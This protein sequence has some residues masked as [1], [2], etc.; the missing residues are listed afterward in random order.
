MK[1]YCITWTDER[2]S[3]DEKALK[4]INEIINSNFNRKRG[5]LSMFENQIFTSLFKNIL[6]FFSEIFE[7]KLGS[8]L[9]HDKSAAR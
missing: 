8:R 6:S 9:K 5:F 2:W 7:K 1:T 4:D 3:A